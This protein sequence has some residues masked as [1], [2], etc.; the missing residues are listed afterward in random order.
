MRGSKRRK[1]INSSGESQTLVIRV[2]K[3]LNCKRIH[4]ELPDILVPYKRYDMESIEAV[5]NEGTSLDVA[6]DDSTISRWK[7]WFR[8]L[9]YHFLGCL[10]SIATRYNEESVKYISKLP[11]S[12]LQR[13]LHFV[14]SAPAWLARVVRSVVNSNNWLHTRSAFMS[15][16]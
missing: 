3:C 8:A 5:I 15:R 13:I 12:V 10:I 11:K 1:R 9:S 6:A 4:H 14:G 16:Y 7:K 2:I